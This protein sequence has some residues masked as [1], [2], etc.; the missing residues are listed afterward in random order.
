MKQSILQVLPVRLSDKVEATTKRNASNY[1]AKLAQASTMLLFSLKFVSD[2]VGNNPAIVDG[3]RSLN[4]IRNVLQY[5]RKTVGTSE[6]TKVTGPRYQKS[7]L[8]RNYPNKSFK[9]Y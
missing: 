9:R 8:L 6:R 4:E 1:N 7:L 3:V 2:F 5:R